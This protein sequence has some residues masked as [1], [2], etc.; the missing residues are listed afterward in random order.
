[1]K[2]KL[3]KCKPHCISTILL[4]IGGLNWGA[5]GIFDL[6][7]IEGIFGGWPWLVTLIYILIG[8][9]AVLFLIE[10]HCKKCK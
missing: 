6:D 7:V 10:G 5:V 2:C 8:I 1:M 9:S 3:D 4:V